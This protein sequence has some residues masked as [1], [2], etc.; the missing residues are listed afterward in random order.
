MEMSAE[1]VVWRDTIAAANGRLAGYFARNK[2][3]LFLVSKANAKTTGA[4]RISH[5][6]NLWE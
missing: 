4:R 6:E 5:A 1:L 3:I 2:N